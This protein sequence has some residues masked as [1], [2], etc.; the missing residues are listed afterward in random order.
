MGVDYMTQWAEPRVTANIT[1][2]KVAKFIFKN[3]FCK[4]GTPF[5]ILLGI[6]PNFR[7]GLIQELVKK[8]EI[9]YHR[10]TPYCL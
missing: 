10:S 9:V 4:F 3:I 7:V 1:A 5:S 2:T 6:R 8:L